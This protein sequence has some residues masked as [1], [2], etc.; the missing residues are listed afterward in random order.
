[1]HPI[2]AIRDRLSLTQNALAAGIGCSQGNV[3]NYERGQSIPP[4][5]ARK[6]IGFCA[7][8]GMEISFD[9]VYGEAPLPELC[10][11]AHVGEAR[12]G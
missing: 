2:K 8:R 3:A 5:M 4:A 12:H 6:L 11:I 9:H 7:S 1:M 10:A